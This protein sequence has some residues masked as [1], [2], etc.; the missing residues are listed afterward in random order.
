MTLPGGLDAS[1]PVCP[2]CNVGPEHYVPVDQGGK[3]GKVRCTVCQEVFDA[4]ENACPVCG[5]GP[6]YFEPVVEKKAGKVRCTICQEVFD[7]SETVC[8]VCG[9]GPGALCAGGAPA[10]GQGQ[11]CH[12]RRYL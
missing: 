5:V 6:E 8:P 10:D 12:L 1:E 3:A 7:A 4:S 9:V 2:F 11:V